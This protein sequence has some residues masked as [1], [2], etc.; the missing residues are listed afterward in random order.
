MA[1]DVVRQLLAT[2]IAL[3]KL[4]ARDISAQEAEQ[5]TSVASS[6]IAVRSL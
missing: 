5:L 4:G 1:R 6:L 3:D 2:D